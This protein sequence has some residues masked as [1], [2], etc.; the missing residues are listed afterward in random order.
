MRAVL[1]AVGFWG[2]FYESA[3]VHSW[4]RQGD[5]AAARGDWAAAIACYSHAE[6]TPH[7]PGQVAFNLAT[8][9][10]HLAANGALR[11]LG[12]AEAG[13]RA[14][15]RGERRGR[16]LLGLGNCLLLRATAGE[17]L[18]PALLRAASDCFAEA[19]ATDTTVAAAARYNRARVRLLLAQVLPLST[20]DAP[21]ESGESS[22]NAPDEPPSPPPQEKQPGK[23][24]ESGTGDQ[25]VPI[26]DAGE[27]PIVEE[28]DR[29][30]SPGKG[31]TPVPSR[32]QAVPLDVADAEAQLREATRRI[33][34]EWRAQRRAR[35]APR[36]GGG[37]DW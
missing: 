23:D 29:P 31:S 8:A 24:G 18:D 3:N 7:D 16:A 19:A 15:L 4:M 11:E 17:Q 35:V 5:A 36:G 27:G 34:E 37:P 28:K 2:L 9:H 20:E 6:A 10:Y 32:P 1:L 14:C 13:Y 25:R 30:G 21:A 26:K 33:L 22:E 12:A